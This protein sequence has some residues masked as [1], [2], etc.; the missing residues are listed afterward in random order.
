MTKKSYILALDQGTTSSRA[1]IF[2]EK[3]EFIASAAETYRQIYPHDG[4]VEHEAQAI[5]QTTI[6]SARAVLARAQLAANEILALGIS[7]QRETTI[8]WDK[9]TGNAI[10][11]AIVW[12]DRRTAKF[13]EKLQ[14]DAN[15]VASVHAKTG[16]LL[17]PYFSA[18]KIAWLLDNVDG[19]RE[20]AEAGQLCFGTVDSFLLWHL[21]GGKEFATDA[22][23]ASRTLL[24]NIVEQCWDDELLAL[25]NIPKQLLPEV[26]NSADNFGVTNAKHFGAEI[27]INALIGDQ[28]AALVGQACFAKGMM[29]ATYGTGGFVMVNTGAKPVWSKHKM[30]TTLAYR[31]NHQ[32]CYAL[33]GS[34]FMAGATMQWLRDELHLLTDVASSQALA[35]SLVG[36][37]SVYLV[38]AFTGLGAPHWQPE[39][40]GAIVGLNRDSGIKEI[41]NAALASVAYQTQDLLM[42]MAQD[43]IKTTQLRVDGGMVVNDWLLQFLADILALTIERPKITET[44]ALGAALLAGLQHGLFSSLEQAAQSWQLQASY[45]P[46]MSAASRQRHY[47]GWLAAL[48]RVKD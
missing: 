10:Y 15:I 23:N 30:L 12:Q 21:T 37:N 22:T 19:A 11:N 45:R 5:W 39:A 8:V 40:R 32:S 46:T 29:K 17:D 4:W 41:V 31:I 16:L 24:F 26:K 3:G 13:C 6:N 18:S 42:A 20:K 25:F 35:Q 38:P 36:E 43:G 34:I 9:D 48:Q 27:A 33:E 7:N 44:S 1:I 47:Q 14:Q 2:S 28:Q